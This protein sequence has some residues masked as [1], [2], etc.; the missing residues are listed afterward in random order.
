M[1]QILGKVYRYQSS[2]QKPQIKRQ[3][4]GQKKRTTGQTTIYET[5]HRKLKIEQHEPNKKKTGVELRCWYMR[6]LYD[7]SLVLC[8]SIRK[9]WYIFKLKW[10][11]IQL[12]TRHNK[13][14]NSVF[15]AVLNFAI[16]VW[17]SSMIITRTLRWV[18]NRP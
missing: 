12:Y 16:T 11:T 4:A 2:N 5:F 8:L 1:L 13:V 17:A 6:L 9:K 3:H 10:E 15:I 18:W 14:K 7:P